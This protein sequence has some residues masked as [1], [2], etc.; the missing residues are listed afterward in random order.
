MFRFENVWKKYL[1]SSEFLVTTL[2]LISATVR[3]L[4]RSTLH[5][6]LLNVCWMDLTSTS[7]PLLSPTQLRL[8][9][10]PRVK[11]RIVYKYV[12]RAEL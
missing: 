1:V 2:F 9:R 8:E 4:Y 6:R 3:L 7:V 10:H 11:K 5:S 12:G